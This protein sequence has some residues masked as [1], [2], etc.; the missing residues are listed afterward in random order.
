MKIILKTYLIFIFKNSAMS[1]HQKKLLGMKQVLF[2]SKTNIKWS[3]FWFKVHIFWE[4]HHQSFDW[5]YIGEII[6][7]KFA[8][9]CGL[10]RIYELYCVLSRLMP[11]RSIWIKNRNFCAFKVEKIWD[12]GSKLLRLVIDN[13]EL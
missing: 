13:L 9:F 11:V 1:W 10:L 4:G 2:F 3:Q 7:G 5:Q 6:G 12:S 8:K